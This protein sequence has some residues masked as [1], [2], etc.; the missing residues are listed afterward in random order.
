MKHLFL[1]LALI[2]TISASLP[3]KREVHESFLH[4]HWKM[5]IG[6][7]SYRTIP[8]V[9]DQK[10]YIGSNGSH[11][12][13]YALDD[14]NGVFSLHA[15]SGK[16]ATTFANE[17]F[18]DMD[19]NGILRLKDALY[20]GNDNDEFICS[21]KQGKFKWRVY[22][23]GDIEHRPVSIQSEGQE[24][25]VFATETGQLTALNAKTGKEVW[26]YYHKDFAAWKPGDN[27]TLFKVKMHFTEGNIFFNEPSL[28]DLTGDGVKDL[29]YNTNWGDFTAINGKTGKLLWDLDGED[30]PDYYLN[31]GRE[32]PLIVGEGVNSQ[33]L[34]LVRDKEEYA[35]QS[36]AFFN[37]KGK[38]V[39]ILP[40]KIPV[41]YALLSQTDGFIITSTAIIQ[42]VAHS[43]EV[44]IIPI[45]NAQFLN[46]NGVL[47]NCYSDGQVAQK[48]VYYN[49]ETCA[50][51]VYQYE[52]KSQSGQSPL[53]LVGLNSGKVHFKTYLPDRSEFTPYISDFNQ[54]GKLDVLIGCYDKYLYCFDLDIPSILLID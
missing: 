48:K 7:T 47:T 41:G 40:T 52:L 51:I 16:I 35:K 17:Q 27:R 34:L 54:D 46:E 11:F 29:V 15:T 13:D 25:V 26:T 53:L 18:G 37:S 20:F 38:R 42:P 23:S 3:K 24:L 30:F 44:K 14:G 5:E 1:I 22:T 43:D 33:I 2:L 32:K 9:V 12:R 31:M 6:F 10:I 49:G 8:V 21:D 4:Q 36:I 45:E 50:L 19:V 39:K 28:A